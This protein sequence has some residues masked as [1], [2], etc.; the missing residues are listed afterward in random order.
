[1]AFGALAAGLP[2][3]SLGGAVALALGLVTL[4]RAA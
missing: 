1:V 4:P 2:A 3:A